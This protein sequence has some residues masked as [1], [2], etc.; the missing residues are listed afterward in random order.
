MPRRNRNARRRP[1]RA[2]AVGDIT[3]GEPLAL[4]GAKSASH[5]LLL[6]SYWYLGTLAALTLVFGSGISLNTAGLA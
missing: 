2:L 3:L 4:E 5:Y 6:F 1:A